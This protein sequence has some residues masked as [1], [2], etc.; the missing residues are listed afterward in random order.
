MNSDETAT[1]AP[2]QPMVRLPLFVR[3]NFVS[4]SGLPMNWKIECDALTD[5]DIDTLAFVIAGEIAFSDVVGVPS[6]GMRLA[7]ALQQYATEGP[8]LIVDDVLTTGRSM[9]ETR[10]RFPGAVGA[11]LFAR[12]HVPDW[13]TAVWVL[14]I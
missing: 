12:G 14:A 7:V 13:I 3:A 1:A 11:V 9:E 4:H 8:V 5:A 6:G 10:E 2:V